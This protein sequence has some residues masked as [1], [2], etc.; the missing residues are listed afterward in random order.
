MKRTSSSHACFSAMATLPGRP[1]TSIII[2]YA[3][4][5]RRI[6]FVDL[7]TSSPQKDLFYNISNDIED[8]LVVVVFGEFLH[9]DCLLDTAAS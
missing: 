5:T 2:S 3:L 8:T 9:H 4:S 1:M 7:N 6:F